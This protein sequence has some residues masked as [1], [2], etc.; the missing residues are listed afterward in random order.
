LLDMYAKCE[1][2]L[3]FY[4][5]SLWIISFDMSAVSHASRD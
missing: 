1:I 2:A 4:A 3:N 5:K